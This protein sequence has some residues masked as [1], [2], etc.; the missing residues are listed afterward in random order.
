MS[1]LKIVTLHCFGS[2]PAKHAGQKGHFVH[3]AQA[4]GDRVEWV[5]PAAPNRLDPEVVRNLLRNEMGCT[6]EEVAAFGL[7]DPRCWFRFT[8]GRYVGLEQSMEFLA[9][10]CGRERPD[11]IAGYSNGGGMA[12]LVAAARES[13][14]PDF[15]SIR[16]LMS[17]CGATSPMMQGRIRE[18]MGPGHAR[19]TIPTILFGSR[20]DPLLANAE[21]MAADLFERCE[22]AIADQRRPF[23]NHALPEEAACYERVVRFMGDRITEGKSL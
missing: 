11:G 14:H 5:Y 10:L 19:I 3:C 6:D 12:Q 4:C 9:E 16:F 7:E 2:N 1:R 20:Y 17:F 21:Q 15:Q 8:D 23:A 22:L 18:I 13:G